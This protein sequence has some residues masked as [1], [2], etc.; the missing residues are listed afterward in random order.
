MGLRVSAEGKMK[1]HSSDLPRA[2]LPSQCRTV[3]ALCPDPCGEG[4]SPL[5][6]LQDSLGAAQPAGGEQGLAA[7]CPCSHPSPSAQ[8]AHTSFPPAV[9]VS[10]LPPPQTVSSDTLGYQTQKNPKLWRVTPG[11]EAMEHD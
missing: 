7:P 11:A 10:Q 9:M 4:R 2:L 3:G 8:A 6:C 5:C 1:A